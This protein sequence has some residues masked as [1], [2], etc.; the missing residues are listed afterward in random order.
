MYLTKN[1][2]VFMNHT[3]YRMSEKVVHSIGWLPFYRLACILW[4]P[5]LHNAFY[6]MHKFLE[7]V[8]VQ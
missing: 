5:R 8:H 2:M 1:L 4:I 3:F 6:R 7:L